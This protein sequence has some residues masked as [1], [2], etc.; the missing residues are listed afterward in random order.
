MKSHSAEYSFFQ[1]FVLKFGGSV[2]APMHAGSLKKQILNL[3]VGL[4]ISCVK[5]QTKDLGQSH[6]PASRMTTT[7]AH[8]Y[9][10]P[11]V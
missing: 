1:A 8:D 10:T 9:D 5:E 2:Q 4:R 3:G 11:Q 6:L 7:E